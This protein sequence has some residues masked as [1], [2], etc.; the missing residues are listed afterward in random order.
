[1]DDSSA[2]VGSSHPRA[3][4]LHLAACRQAAPDAV[5][6]AERLFELETSTDLF[7]DALDTHAEVLGKAGRARYAELADAAWVAGPP[8]WRLKQIMERLA[9]GDVDRLV[10][11]K[12]RT[13]EHGW[14][15]L[16]I[17][18]LLHDAGRLEDA[19][20]WAQRGVAAMPDARLRE[21]L[22]DCLREVGRTEAALAQR[23]RSS[24]SSH[25]GRPRRCGPRPS[26]SA[27]GRASVRRRW[28]CSSSPRLPL[29][30]RSVCARGD[31]AVGERRR[32]RVGAG[33]RWRLLA[34]SLARAGPRAP[35]DAVAVYRRLLSATIDLRNGSGY[36][37]AIEL[38][39][40]LH[41]LLA[42]LG[43]EDEHAALVTEV[44]EVHRRKTNLIKR[45]DA[46]QWEAPCPDASARAVGDA[47][48]R[49]QERNMSST[50]CRRWRRSA[51]TGKA[52]S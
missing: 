9:A 15:Y 47:L 3:Q 18:T 29:A 23:P 42:P 45:L 16:E 14:D 8:S 21:F 43:R 40:E 30:A 26:R 24:A 28:P 27:P 49:M 17:A 39:A 7:E 41:L 33:A 5:A 51:G 25:A 31:P 52:R 38:L 4:E 6:L 2:A 13:V 37:G 48:A 1:M 32:R 46:Q 19:I 36:D 12:A 35:D 50:P 20:V 11:I 34:R 10:A 22:A 44:R